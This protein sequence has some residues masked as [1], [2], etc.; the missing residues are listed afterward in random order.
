MSRTTGGPG[1]GAGGAGVKPDVT[2]FVPGVVP[3]P[4][5]RLF[6]LHVGLCDGV[7]SK[8]QAKH[9]FSALHEAQQLA[10]VLPVAWLI[11]LP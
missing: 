4:L 5:Q 8:V 9:P 3:F 1:G 7:V 11:S 6:M 10:A 2:H